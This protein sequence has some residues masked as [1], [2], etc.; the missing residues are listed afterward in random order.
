MNNI[1]LNSKY[2]VKILNLFT[3]FIEKIINHQT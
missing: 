2:V 3:I 1:Q